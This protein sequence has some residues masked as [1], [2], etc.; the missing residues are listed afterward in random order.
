MRL[1]FEAGLINCDSDR[2]DLRYRVLPDLRHWSC[3]DT[4]F[5]LPLQSAACGTAGSRQSEI[6]VDGGTC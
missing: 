1:S 3:D 6:L 2:R 4:M 5:T